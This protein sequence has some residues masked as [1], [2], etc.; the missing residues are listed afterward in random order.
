MYGASDPIDG[1]IE[2]LGLLFPRTSIRDPSKRAIHQVNPP[3]PRIPPTDT[4]TGARVL[5]LCRGERVQ[6]DG[7]RAAAGGGGGRAAER[8][9]A[10][11]AHQG[12]DVSTRVCCMCM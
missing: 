1:L 4:L 11:R 12:A 8:G 2:M 5:G 9:E 10:P 7:A 6:D 3:I